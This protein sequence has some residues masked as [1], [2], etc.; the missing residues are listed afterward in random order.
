MVYDPRVADCPCY[1]C[2][3]QDASDARLNCAEN[4]VAAPVVGVVGTIQALEAM[5]LIVG[6]GESLAGYL[7]VFDAKIMEW[8]KLVLPRN[9]DCTTCGR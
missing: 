2:L 4:G 6:L 1:R 5:K 9:P 8:R 7:L 3:Y